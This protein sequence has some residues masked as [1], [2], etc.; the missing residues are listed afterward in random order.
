MLYN[1]HYITRARFNTFLHNHNHNDNRNHKMLLC[2][3]FHTVS[4]TA[5][6]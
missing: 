5:H 4:H 3:V 6:M 1:I 2:A